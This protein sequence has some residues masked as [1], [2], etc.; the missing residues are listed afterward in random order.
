MTT[1]TQAE[2]H[3]HLVPHAPKSMIIC[4][5]CPHS[6]YV[7]L[8]HMSSQHIHTLLYACPNNVFWHLSNLS[9]FLA[10][11][12][13]PQC[14]YV[15]LSLV[16]TTQL[17]L[18]FMYVPTVCI[19]VSILLVPI[20]DGNSSL[21]LHV[22]TVRICISLTCPHNS[23]VIFLYACSHSGYMHLSCSPNKY[24]SLSLVPIK[25]VNLFFLVI[26]PTVWIFIF[27]LALTTHLYLFL[28]MHAP[29]ISICIS[30]TCPH[31]TKQFVSPYVCPHSD[32]TSLLLLPIKHGNSFSLC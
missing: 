1:S 22:P 29:T 30:F 32:Y 17:Y 14:A 5:A 12:V 11:C 6:V 18:L 2:V 25:H 13:S 19:Y 27:H 26:V 23:F 20:K 15:S 4:Y 8:S 21:L 7:H 28:F 10:P 24:G 3:A 31:K 16:R 9:Q